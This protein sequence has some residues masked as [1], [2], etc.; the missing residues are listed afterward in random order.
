MNESLLCGVIV[1]YKQSL[2]QSKT[3]ASLQS[4]EAGRRLPLFVYDNSPTKGALPQDIKGYLHDS[5]NGGVLGAYRWAVEQAR[6][7]GFKWILLLDQ[8]SSIPPELLDS[9]FRLADVVDEDTVAFIPRVDS[10]GQEVS[11]RG[12]FAGVPG[13]LAISPYHVGVHRIPLTAINSGAIVRVDFLS[14][15][16]GFN[17]VDALDCVDRCMF[18]R[19]YDEGR[20]VF[21]MPIRLSH[22]L[23]VSNVKEIG[24]A[25]WENI[26]RAE[27]AYFV[28]RCDRNSAVMGSALMSL[29]AVGGWR[30]MHAWQ[31]RMRLATA[32]KILTKSVF[33]RKKHPDQNVK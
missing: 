30:T 6:V 15:P 18:Q 19:I 9:F 28:E 7:H 10:G 20:N 4:F 33:R 16:P 14:K 3:Y 26:C 21:I 32:G 29:G 12:V 25:R 8:D 23:S 22:E 11:P 13:P 1:L 2:D 31:L 27:Q 5:E 24:R 17:A